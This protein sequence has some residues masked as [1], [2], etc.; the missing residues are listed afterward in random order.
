MSNDI[1][2]TMLEQSLRTGFIDSAAPSE[3]I[4]RPQLITNNHEEHLDV[5]SVIK[6]ELAN[7]ERFDFSVAFI[8]NSGVQV[9][10]EILRELELRGV[11][12]RI[13]TTTYLD[14]NS[15]D[16][17]E[18]LMNF[19]NIELRVYEGDLHTKGYFF[20]KD[21][22]KTMLV[23]SSNLT[24]S[25]LRSNQE[26]NLLVHSTDEGSIASD[27][28]G[29][30]E[31]LWNSESTKPI[32]KEWIAE[33]RKHHK[34]NA[35]R[36]TPKVVPIPRA[37][38]K[39][40]SA[41]EQD[42]PITPN[43]MQRNALENIARLR[44]LGERKALLISAT[45]TG[46]TYLAALDVRS[47][48]P[49]RALFVVHRE[50][51]A[52]AAMESFERV[53]GKRRTYG[54]YTGGQRDTRADFLFCTIQTL[55]LHLNEFDPREFDYIIIDEAHRS[56]ASSYQKVLN[57]FDPGFLLGMTATPD[58]SDGYDIY[59]LFGN[60]IAYQITL[61]DA[62]ENDLLA[63]FHY[64]GITDLNV[65]G[66]EI[67]DN[68][69]FARLTSE[70]RVRHIIGQINSYTVNQERRGLIFCSRNEEAKRLSEM[71]NERGFRTVALSGKNTD[72]EREWCVERLEADRSKRDDW[73]EYIF[74]V[75]IF[76]EGVDIPSL[77]QIIMLRPT[78]SAIIFVQQLGRGLRKL[79]NKEYVLVLDFIGNY[80]QSFLIP[81]ALSG[82]RSGNKDNLRRYVDEGSRII[83]GNSSV[84][85]D[86]IAKERIYRTLDTA[87]FGTI[88]SLREG[89]TGL[90][91][92]LGRIPSLADFDFYDSVDPLLI[93]GHNSLGSYHAFL[94][95]YENEYTVRFTKKEEQALTFVSK[96]LSAGKRPHELLI[97]EQ[98]LHP[99][100]KSVSDLHFQRMSGEEPAYLPASIES[101]ANVLSGKFMTG[102]LALN[103]GDCCLVEHHN[104][105][106][107]R[108][109]QFE[110][111]LA[112]S[113]FAA[114]L[115]EVVEFGLSRFH[116]RYENT[117][118]GTDL[119]LYEKY[120][121]FDVCR[122]LNW[123]ENVSGQNIGGYKYDEHTNTFPVF[124]NYEKA[125]DISKTIRYEDRFI[126][127]R[128]L[129]AI[130]KSNRSMQSNEIQ[131]LKNARLNH[132]CT[133]LFV[134]KNKDD[135]ESKEFYFLGEMKP[136]GKF[137]Q[138]IMPGTDSSAV[139][140]VY[141]LDTPVKS[142]LFDYITS[143]S[144]A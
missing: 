35:L 68:A 31:R 136:T 103:Y 75:D 130:S 43:L 20:T 17:L 90:R 13:L 73:L 29:E 114:E 120:T 59:R 41:P 10:V 38:E 22:M 28:Y 39:V 23:G 117:Y 127:N 42:F 9:L 18:R 57:H 7:C 30:F 74:T 70:E 141:T 109:E 55:A 26:W 51:I 8:A 44:S 50:R 21:S 106:F 143:G 110:N 87:R 121:Y 66:Y 85:F 69:D 111:M 123:K 126:D 4:L 16:A 64:F 119:V 45:G 88:K 67:D 125:D 89:Y 142:E 94:S 122:L 33:Y 81:V 139:E 79:P 62:E 95:K 99:N 104:G 34:P 137:D 138:I 128:T 76:N 53:I 115:S 27:A 71:F 72:V 102:A 144:V 3:V 54:T 140:I 131:R 48:M 105:Y 24:Q 19:M 1:T 46:K 36:P 80:Q 32:T 97:L 5:L 118:R 116:L 15:P 12:G 56:G 108:S 78:Q 77:N 61:Q 93:F 133:Y 60:N 49:K 82:D 37:P 129:V 98:L 135:A 91:N 113:I 14:F 65:E 58:R 100:V 63:P 40:A 6:R 124:I 86:R 132:M 52:R 2:Y 112:N 107:V 83:P 92:M 84:N 25:A 101:V 47:V 96:F 11:H 134:R